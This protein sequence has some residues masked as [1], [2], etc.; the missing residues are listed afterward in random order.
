MS[1]FGTVYNSFNEM[2][3]GTGA[4][5]PEV[6]SQM[7]AFNH[8]DDTV[9]GNFSGQSIIWNAPDFTF[10][11][12][13]VDMCIE[14]YGVTET[15]E[16]SVDADGQDTD[17]E[18]RRNVPKIVASPIE[19]RQKYG[20]P[21]M[22]GQRFWVKLPSGHRFESMYEG[23]EISEDH[24]PLYFTGIVSGREAEVEVVDVKPNGVELPNGWETKLLNIG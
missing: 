7:S 24:R 17:T 14:R 23:A 10:Q 15:I 18:N 2:A 19:A 22:R 4:I 3:A 8:S 20:D 12:R 21:I 6:Q 16:P 5:L 11:G 13:R 1:D 9:H